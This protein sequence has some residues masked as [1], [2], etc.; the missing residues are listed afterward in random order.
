MQLLHRAAAGLD[1]I[2]ARAN[3]I[4]MVVWFG[5]LA[6]LLVAWALWGRRPGKGE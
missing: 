6:F 2:S 3:T 5:S 4:L 1:E